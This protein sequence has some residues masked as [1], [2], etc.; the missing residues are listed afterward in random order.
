MTHH[1]F[2]QDPE[3]LLEVGNPVLEIHRGNQIMV[4]P[5]LEF[6]ARGL[7]RTA[8]LILEMRYV[9]S[10]NMV[11]PVQ[12]Y[13]THPVISSEEPYQAMGQ[14]K[15]AVDMAEIPNQKRPRSS[16]KTTSKSEYLLGC[17]R[18][19]PG[20]AAVNGSVG[21]AKGT[22]SFKIPST[23]QARRCQIWARA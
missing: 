19:Q 23:W 12:R 18:S 5:L 10:L 4:S 1:A 14:V 17:C 3:V 13:R 15:I 20:Y 21:C 9:P 6:L 2:L 22:S 8:R 11:E 7:T 16:K